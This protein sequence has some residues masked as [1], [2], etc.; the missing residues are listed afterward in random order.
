MDKSPVDTNKMI[1]EMEEYLYH[2][3]SVTQE[4][5]EGVMQIL[6]KYCNPQ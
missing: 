2:N 1:A 5:L 6:D 4:V 3:P